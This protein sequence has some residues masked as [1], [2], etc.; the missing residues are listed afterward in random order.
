MAAVEAAM[1]C[2]PVVMSDTGCATWLADR[3][4]TLVV[5]SNE[6]ERIADAFER[7][8]AMHVEPLRLSTT[9]EDAARQQ[10]EWWKSL[11]G[12]VEEKL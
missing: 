11:R 2:V 3:G 4:Q 6:P 8:I 5:R 9:P 1:V 10:V 7:A 12:H